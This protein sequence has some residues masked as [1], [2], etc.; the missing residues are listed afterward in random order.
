M[1][2]GLRRRLFE[3][4][5][6]N[7]GRLASPAH[8]VDTEATWSF[9]DTNYVPLLAGLGPESRV[10]EIGG[11][12]G[13]FLTWLRAR[14]FTNLTGIEASPGDAAHATAV[15]GDGVVHEGDGFAFA[16]A[17]PGAFDLVMM[18]AV[19]EHVPKHE[20]VDA[21]DA[22]VVALAAG[23]RLIVEVP[24]MDW[25]FAMHERYLDLTHEVGFT[26]ESLKS[27]LGLF[28]Q[29]VRVELSRIDR[30]TRLQRLA[31][32]LVVSLT[33]RLLYVFGE[34]AS[35]FAFASRSLI[36]AARTPRLPTPEDAS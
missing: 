2:N 24:N 20:L 11:G 12:P 18:K 34:G 9:F 26:P 21:L 25:L 17:N 8:Y 16:R 23:G 13:Q 5:S 29:D 6:D 14:G 33:R 32:P 4:Y 19:L 28:F 15:L 10:L 22:T 27:L 1:S 36:A 35:D 30:P 7:Q 31:R 3:V